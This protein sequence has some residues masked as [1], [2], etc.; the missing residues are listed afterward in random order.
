MP[1]ECR[2]K[3]QVSAALSTMHGPGSGCD[4]D[5]Q[6]ILKSHFLSADQVVIGV[7]STALIGCCILLRR[8]ESIEGGG[9]YDDIQ[10]MRNYLLEALLSA[11]RGYTEI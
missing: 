3:A 1:Y 6:S 2:M 9:S 8:G 10:L 5:L 11:S 7:G 4:A